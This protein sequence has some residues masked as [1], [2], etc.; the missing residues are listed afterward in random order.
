[1]SK[2]PIRRHLP[3]LLGLA[4]GIA[5][6]IILWLVHPKAALVGGAITFFLIYLV[7]TATRFPISR[8]AT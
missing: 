8:R 7:H 1:M 6:S 3:F 5:M 4:A 2:S